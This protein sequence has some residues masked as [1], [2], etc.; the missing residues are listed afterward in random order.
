VKKPINFSSVQA[1][2]SYEKARAAFPIGDERA[3]QLLRDYKYGIWRDVV[4]Y[5][6]PSSLITF[7]GNTLVAPA[8]GIAQRIQNLPTNVSGGAVTQPSSTRKA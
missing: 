5:T 7:V 8:E 3:R 4:Q 1:P 2:L 6:L